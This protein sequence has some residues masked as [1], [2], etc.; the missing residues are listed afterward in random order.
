M[1][2]ISVFLLLLQVHVIHVSSFS[3][4]NQPSLVELLS[5]P[6]THPIPRQSQRRYRSYSCLTAAASD[7]NEEEEKPPKRK[8][9]YNL[10]VGKNPPV[11]SATKK[12]M[13]KSDQSTEDVQWNVPGHPNGKT[14]NESKTRKSLKESIVGSYSSDSNDDGNLQ[15]RRVRRMVARTEESS[16]L[17]GA[18]WHEEHY[19]TDD[20]RDETAMESTPSP[21]S[22]A[23]S[24]DALETANGT[25]APMGPEDQEGPFKRPELFYPN[26]DLSIPPSVYNP[27]TSTDIVWDLM[28]WEAFRE[29]QREPLLVSFLYSSILNHDSLESSLAFLLANKLSSAAMISTQVQSLILDA[30]D[31]D[32]SIG[33]SIRA[34]IMVSQHTISWQLSVFIEFVADFFP[35]RFIA[36]RSRSRSRLHLSARCILVFQGISCIANLPRRSCHLEDGQQTGVGTL[37]SI[38]NVP[39]ISNRYPPKRDTRYV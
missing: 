8:S 16:T 26:I 15:P 33:R 31:K 28:R 37:P 35:I 38:A 4:Q 32:P 6:S 25:S 1:T 10:G 9:T 18:I 36:G 19:S 34:D 3:T 12:T 21:S 30:L 23:N 29:A 7:K 2:L 11:G 24:T 39:N 17:R 20:E 5:K 14:A 13:D 22:A 27:E